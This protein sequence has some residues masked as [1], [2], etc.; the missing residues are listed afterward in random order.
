MNG[1][2]PNRN[3][4]KA[5]AFNA[6]FDSVFDRD[7]G[8]REFQRCELEDQGCRNEQLMVNPEIV[9]EVL[10]Q[11]NPNKTMGPDGIYSRILKE[12][13][14]V[15]AKPLNDFW[16]ILGICRSLSWLEV[17]E[18][19]LSFHNRQEGERWKLGSCQSYFSAQLNNGKDY[20]G[21]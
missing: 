1:H 9:Q 17:G 11:L 10:L 18:G 5:K 13:A 20:S 19:F 6:F 12:L 7:N 14:D 15:I 21:K 2:L 4:G 8:P 3:R 16:T